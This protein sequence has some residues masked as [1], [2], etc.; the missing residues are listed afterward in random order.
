MLA[1]NFSLIPSTI[2]FSASFE[3][4]QCNQSSDRASSLENYFITHTV[5]K[6]TQYLYNSNGRKTFPF[7]FP[8]QV[9]SARYS[10]ACL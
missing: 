10:G 8:S 3:L 7:H 5:Y 9:L 4:Y 6:N 1:E 2:N